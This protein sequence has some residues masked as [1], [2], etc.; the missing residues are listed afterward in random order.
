M[1][2]SPMVD[3]Y[4]VRSPFLILRLPVWPYLRFFGE[5]VSNP[6]CILLYIIVGILT[7][8]VFIFTRCIIPHLRFWKISQRICSD[9]EGLP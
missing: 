3:T 9:I 2:F 5:S 8:G 1:N 7:I 4:L 6:I